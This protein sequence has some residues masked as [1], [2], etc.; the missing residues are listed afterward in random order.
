MVGPQ[1]SSRVQWQ[2]G[3]LDAGLGSRCRHHLSRFFLV[4]TICYSVS[5]LRY[6]RLLFIT[7]VQAVCLQE[8]G[9]STQFAV[10]FIKPG[11]MPC[12]QHSMRVKVYALP[13]CKVWRLPASMRGQLVLASLVLALC[14]VLRISLRRAREWVLGS[15]LT[16][17]FVMVV[18]NSKQPA[19]LLHPQSNQAAQ[20][21]TVIHV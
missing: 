13:P 6:L 17:C 18:T 19:L 8:D 7:L 2:L 4:S 5:T 15:K 16:C 3:A 11:N 1:P 12:S 20:P 10:L 9:F 14:S 21:L